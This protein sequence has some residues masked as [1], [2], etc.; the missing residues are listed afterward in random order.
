MPIRREFL[1]W[2]RPALPAAAEWLRARRAAEGMWDLSGLIVAVPGG[3]AGRRLLEVLVATAEAHELAFAPPRIITPFALPEE[4]YEPR[5][6]FADDFTQE[7]A[8]VRALRETDPDRLRRIARALPEDGDLFGWFAL[9]RLVGQLHRDLAADDLDFSQVIA[10]AEHLPAFDEAERWEILADVQSRYLRIL[11][12]L[13]VWDRQTARLVAIRK[14]EC[15]TECDIVLVGT[16]DMN[17]AQ[18]Q[19]LDQ[20]ADRVTALVFAPAELE[21]RFDE[22]GCV[23]PDAWRELPTPIPEEIVEI[24][25]G[26]AEQADATL[27]AL[28]AF[29]GRYAADEITIGVPDARLVP[30]LA[31]RFAESELPHRYGVGRTVEQT[32]PYRLLEAIAEHLDQRDAA[33]MAALLRHPALE[34]WLRQDVGQAFQPAA[35]T[36]VEIDAAD[37]SPDRADKDVRPTGWVDDELLDQLDDFRA[38]HLPTRLDARRIW[39]AIEAGGRYRTL[40]AA[41]KKVEKLLAPLAKKKRLPA[42]WTDPIR[43]ILVACHGRGVLDRDD[44]HDRETLRACD[45][46]VDAAE[47][48]AHAHPALAPELRGVEMLRL[49]LSASGGAVVP[50]PMDE[51]AIELLGWLELPLDDAPAL[52]LTGFNEGL[53]PGSRNADLF[54]PNELRRHLQLEDNDRRFARDAYALALLAASRKELRIIVGRRSSEG[55]PLIP[56]RLLFAGAEDRAAERTL[57]W[58]ATP[59]ARSRILLPRSLLAKATGRT[60]PI[61]PLARLEESV[62]SMKVTEFRDYLAC[63]YRYYLRHRLKL[64]ACDDEA[65]ELDAGAFGT[66][67]HDALYRFGLD[68][69]LRGLTDSADVKAALD[70]ILDARIETDYGDDPLPAVRVQLEQLRRRLWAFAH[71]QAEWTALG[72]RIRYVEQSFADDR[73]ALFDVDDEPMKLRGKIDRIDQHVELGEWVVFDY[74]SGESAASPAKTHRRKDVWIDLQLPLYRHLTRLLEDVGTE[75]KLG[76]IAIPKG[77]AQTKHHLAEWT[78]ADFDS[79][80]EAARAVIR[81]IR[82]NLW[83]ELKPVD[84]PPAFFDDFAAICQDG[85]FGAAAD[86]EEDGGEET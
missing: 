7:L 56:S 33:S 84:P 13:D 67:L 72:W 45:A 75:L 66:L 69:A 83:S 42:E 17:R 70:E 74:K 15:R 36:P 20:V 4:L 23:I 39:T 68:E 41:I 9:G 53:V 46:I 26:P 11:D 19:M 77:A 57:K 81:G 49:V 5:L 52:V 40:H 55:D 37:D 64:A 58:F 12:A 29:D 82:A 73:Q 86:D 8:W 85:R 1:D 18:R 3:H 34:A 62:T 79:A 38:A 24:A 59:P 47:R 61:P 32:G 14:R 76:Y 35:N 16:V 65:E 27:R 71:W 44:P 25:D 10:Q 21:D 22:H 48:L 63:P 54:L 30:W 78:L 51:P 2:S 80:D 43:E 31:Q 50:P 28:A 60:F 6:P